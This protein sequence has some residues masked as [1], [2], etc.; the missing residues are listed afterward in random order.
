MQPLPVLREGSRSTSPSV[1]VLSNLDPLS[2]KLNGIFQHSIVIL[3]TEG[4][5]DML[6]LGL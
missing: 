5:E 4:Q 2:K 3:E 1:N 6:C